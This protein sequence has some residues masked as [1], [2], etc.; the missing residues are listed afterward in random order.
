MRRLIVEIRSGSSKGE[1][2]TLSAGEAL[3]VGRSPRADLALPKDTEMSALHFAL[4]WDGAAC[5]LRDLESASGTELHGRRVEVTTVK[6]GGWIRA[7]S[8]DFMV[9]VE[10][11]T[12]PRRR[13]PDRPELAA[14]KERAIEALRAAEAPLYAVFDTAQDRRIL[15]LLRESVEEHRSLYEGTQG[16]ALADVA[17]YIVRLSPSPSP[18]PFSGGR[19]LE[20][21]VREGWGKSWGIYFTSRRPFKEIRRHLRRFLIVM[22]DETRERLYFRFYDPR[23]LREF[24]PTCTELQLTELYGEPLGGIE[25]FFTE[26]EDNE[27]LMF[28]RP[29][30]PRRIGTE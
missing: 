12:P 10:G 19:L 21:L 9:Y 7:G 24:L 6:N 13:P 15:T 26:G 17:P 27:V 5:R 25:R 28:A 4:E 8:T 18:S 23:V 3:R 20:G 1:K 16:D 2:V 22:D 29:G 30:A 11:A 14:K